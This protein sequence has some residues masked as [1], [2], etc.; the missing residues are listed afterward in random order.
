MTYEEGQRWDKLYNEYHNL[1]HV[2]RIQKAVREEH[3]R[4]VDNGWH[5]SDAMEEALVK[6]AYKQDTRP[7][8][9]ADGAQEYEDILAAEKLMGG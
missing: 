2:P 6:H 7:T 1:Y 8:H 3:K 9:M 5:I 4:L